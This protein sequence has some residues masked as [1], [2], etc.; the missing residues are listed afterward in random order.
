MKW[1]K[2]GKSNK[3]DRM[4]FVRYWAEYVKTHSDEDWS[5][6]QRII[7]DSQIKN[8]K[9]YKLTAKQYLQLQD[10]TNSEIV[11]HLLPP[12]FNIGLMINPKK[13][14]FTDPRIRKA[15][16]LALD[17]QQINDI[18][19]DGTG[20]VTTIF[21]PGMAYAEAEAIKWPG[22]RPKNTQGGKQDLAEAKKLM[23][24]AGFPDGFETT[25]D[26][27][28]VSNYVQVCEVVQEQLK[29]TLGI[30][31]VVRTY[32]SAEGYALYETARPAYAEGDWGLA[33]QGEGTTVLDPD[34]V[35]RGVYRKGAVRNYTDW[36]HPL[37]EDLFERQTVERDLEKRR[38]LNRNAA[39]FL[40]SFDD[41]HW[42]TL[43]WGRFFWP[44]HR[45]IKGFNP[46]QTVQYGFKHE[47]LRLD[48]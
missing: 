1:L 44:I 2:P 40:R 8:A 13:S 37:I 46:P 11:A 7:R 28:S 42:V 47:D 39:D 35:Y 9:H 45:D 26:S 20:G 16:Y 33:C 25:L 18:V 19:L 23:A 29:T 36:S 4:N 22:V 12:S 6:Q 14:P 48:R 38:Q 5:K 3:E 32:P 34:G 31:S 30:N 27:R 15:I 17:R 24:E 43:A 41:N 10:D 21:V